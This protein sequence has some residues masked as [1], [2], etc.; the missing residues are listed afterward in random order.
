MMWIVKASR[1]VFLSPTPSVVVKSDC[2]CCHLFLF[3]SPCPLHGLQRDRQKRIVCA[4][5]SELAREDAL[6]WVQVFRPG[7]QTSAHEFFWA[8]LLSSTPAPAGGVE[9]CRPSFCFIQ[10]CFLCCVGTRSHCVAQDGQEHRLRARV[11][12][13]PTTPFLSS[14][15]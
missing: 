1:A 6:G 7:L 13:T 12:G 14:K 15:I 4:L 5:S 11:I 9:F 3:S 10:P 2:G 8:A